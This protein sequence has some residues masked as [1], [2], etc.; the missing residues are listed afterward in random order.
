MEKGMMIRVFF[1]TWIAAWLLC[2]CRQT[3]ELTSEDYARADRYMEQSV[4]QEYGP[5]KREDGK[6]FCIGYVDIDPYPPSGEMLYYLVRQLETEGWISLPEELPFDPQDTDARE[7]VR[8]LAG[9]DIGEYLEFSDDAC[10]YLA[11]DGEEHCRESLE[12]HQKAGDLDLI[13]CMGTWPGQFVQEMGITE[14]P[15][16]VYFCVDPVGAGLSKGNEYSGQENLWCHVNYTVYNMQLKFYHDNFQFENIGMVYYDESVAAMR[17]Y[18]EVAAE[19]GFQITEAKIE[20]LSEAD[21]ESVKAYYN[22]LKKVFL[23]MAEE[24]KI[25]AFMLGTDIIKDRDRITEL[26]SVFYRNKIPV[27]VQNGE[28]FVQKGALILVTASDAKDQAP[29]AAEAF[30]AILNGIKPG[31]IPQEYLSPPYVCLNLD[32]ADQVG[33]EISEDLLLSAGKIYMENRE[34][35]K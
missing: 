28:Y 23:H 29:F 8:Y 32:A 4:E 35:E 6:K 15:V 16:M 20:M 13:L 2:G 26:L 12:R 27:F 19:Q 33:Y 14:I 31:D 18:R 24:E 10:Y 22:G 30:S 17:A 11:V 21:E 3:G 7:L 9:R 5:V 34:E 25:D 1:L